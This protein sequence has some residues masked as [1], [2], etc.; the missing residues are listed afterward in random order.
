[1]GLGLGYSSLISD[2]LRDHGKELRA[3]GEECQG[4]SVLQFP[5]TTVERARFACTD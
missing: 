2:L 3:E 5:N 4:S 1:M